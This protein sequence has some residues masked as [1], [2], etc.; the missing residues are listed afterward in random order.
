MEGKSLYCLT[1]PKKNYIKE[2]FLYILTSFNIEK[3]AYMLINN[4]A[5]K[6]NP[7]LTQQIETFFINQYDYF[8]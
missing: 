4:I 5:L 3:S 2:G 6:E 1:Y 7:D 8:E